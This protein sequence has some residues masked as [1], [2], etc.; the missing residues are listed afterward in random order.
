MDCNGSSLPSFS[1]PSLLKPPDVILP[2]PSNCYVSRQVHLGQ[3]GN[4]EHLQKYSYQLVLFAAF[5]IRGSAF[6]NSKK[7]E[8]DEKCEYCHHCSVSQGLGRFLNLQ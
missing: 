6:W 4:H 2:N 1:I 3:V 5:S 7:Y 8:L